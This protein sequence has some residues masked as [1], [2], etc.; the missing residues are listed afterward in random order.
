MPIDMTPMI[1]IVFQ[2]L[3]FFIMTLKI[4]DAEGDFNI[5]MPLSAPSSG[6][7]D[8]QQIPPIKMRLVAGSSGDLTDIVVN[9]TSFGRPSGPADKA[10]WKAV[11]N[12]VAGFVGDGSLS[13]SASVEIDCDYDLHYA[14]VIDAIT[15]V[16]GSVG[17]NRELIKLVE[18]IKFTP[19]HQPGN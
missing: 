19:P 4:A 1:D 11:H 16:S 3:V 15:S 10:P 9:E 6:V 2:L 17:P 5:K 8:P 7:P 13:E 18:N 14:H 12:Y